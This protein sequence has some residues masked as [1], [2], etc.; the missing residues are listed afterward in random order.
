[1]ARHANYV[2]LGVIP[3]ALLPFET[4]LSIDE[5]SFRKHLRDVAAVE[6]LSAVTINAHST[7]VGSCTFEEQRRVLDIAQDEIGGRLPLINGI[8]ADGSMEAAR[9]AR[10]AEQGGASA[11]LVFPPAPFTL[12]QSPAMALAHFKRIADATDL[13]L[14]MFQYPLATG[15][16]F[17]KDTLLKLCDAVPSV[18]AIKDWIG[19]VP[20]HEWHIRTLQN[21]PRPVNVLTTHSS[22]LFSSLVLG[23]N[24]LLSG[25]GSVI[26]DLQA[27]LFRAVQ[28]ND[29]AEAKR[30]N[31]RVEPTARVFYADPFVDMH[32]RMKEALVLLGKLPRA[33]VRPPLVKLERAEIVRIRQALIESGLL[34][35]NAARDAA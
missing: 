30:L 21:L 33:V 2:P 20:H 4:D 16:G 8:W 10:M 27:Q 26:A 5:G 31:D 28:K 14:I 9:I 34:G 6:G 7:E 23:C 11:L 15:Q 17:P 32:N 22:W 24:G 25:S 35:K 3:A 19:N 18:R 29:M 13:P 12:G 1:M